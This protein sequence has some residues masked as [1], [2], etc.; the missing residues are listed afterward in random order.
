MLEMNRRHGLLCTYEIAAGTELKMADEQRDRVVYWPIILTFVWPL[1]LIL[2]RFVPDA[3]SSSGMFI[4][5]F[6]CGH[7]RLLRPLIIC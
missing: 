3:V 1:A 7:C 6:C 2:N 4:F 5:F